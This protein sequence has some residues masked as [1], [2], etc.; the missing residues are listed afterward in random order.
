MYSIKKHVVTLLVCAALCTTTQT[1]ENDPCE[2]EWSL[3]ETLINP[4]SSPGANKTYKAWFALG[5]LMGTANA[6]A[7]LTGQAL[8]LPSRHEAWEEPNLLWPFSKKI[9]HAF[10]HLGALTFAGAGGGVVWG[11]IVQG[12][13]YLRTPV[14]SCCQNNHQHQ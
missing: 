11:G 5:A 9:L 10:G 1:K 14:C 12:I 8:I 7:C 3:R 13:S 6:Y 4:F 2:K